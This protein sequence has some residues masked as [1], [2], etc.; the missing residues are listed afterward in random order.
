MNNLSSEITQG[1]FSFLDAETLPE[2]RLISKET[3]DSVSSN[4]EWWKNELKTYAKKR[5]IKCKSNMITTLTIKQYRNVKN[6]IPV[7]YT[8]LTLP[9][10]YSV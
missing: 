5:L 3:L 6:K 4:E 2:T 10:I 7:S 8:H 9:T 1:I